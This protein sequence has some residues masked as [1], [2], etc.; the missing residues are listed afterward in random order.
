VQKQHGES[1][2]GFL[3][4][5]EALSAMGKSA[6]AAVPLFEGLQA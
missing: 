3:L 5:G 2:V 1:S 6:D 4:E